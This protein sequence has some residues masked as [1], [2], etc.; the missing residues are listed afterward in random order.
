M[1]L[2]KWMHKNWDGWI[3]I[4]GL[5]ITVEMLVL[6]VM[7]YCGYNT[8]MF[9][10]G[11]MAQAIWSGTRGW[12]LE[13]TYNG[14]T[15]SRL[16]LHVELIYFLW[17]PLYA[18][19]P[20]PITL[21]TIQALLY[22]LGAFPLYHL[23]LRRIESVGAARIAVLIYLFYPVAQTAVLFDFHGD[24][25]AMPLLLFVL[26]ALD[27]R[28]WRTYA[29]WVGLALSCKFYVAWVVGTLGVMLWLRG[30]RRVG[31]YTALAA[32]LWGI[33]SFLVLRPLFTGASAAV[34]QVTPE[35]YWE[36]YFGQLVTGLSSTALARLLMAFIVFTPVFCLGSRALNWLILAVIVALPVLLSSGAGPS[37]YYGHHHYAM[38]VHF[39][40][41]SVVY[42]AANLK[43]AEAKKK[44]L[45]G[46]GYR[47][48]RWSFGMGITL[49]LTLA[50]N[51]Q[52][53]DTPLRPQFWRGVE[54]QGLSEWRYGRTARDEMKDLWLRQVVPSEASLSASPF[55]APHVVNRRFIYLTQSLDGSTDFPDYPWANAD[56]VVLDGLFDYVKPLA[57]GQF[58]GGSRFDL[59]PL[60]GVLADP[61]FALTASRDGLVL[62]QRKPLSGRALSQSIT[63]SATVS[64]PSLRASWGN[65]IGLSDVQIEVL[66]NRRF[67]FHYDWVGLPALESQPPLFAVS[68]LQ[69][70]ANARLLHLPGY[71]MLPTPS[72][73]LENVVHEEFEVEIAANLP[74]GRYP[75]SVGWYD[76]TNM[77]AYAT[78]ERSRI[79]TLYQVGVLE[80]R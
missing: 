24:T 51:A 56:Y 54:G 9:D 62:F 6:S 53:V 73:E 74:P 20:S 10:I 22:G 31:C 7:R 59:E 37:Y 76:S 28:A 35:G 46:V 26:E 69:G 38:V 72:W 75:V 2:L 15:L 34:A 13:F 65:A 29:V 58:S 68:Q 25:L 23:A 39:L 32:V 55:L 36:F 60:A 19:F 57:N 78:D 79:G 66:G 5:L 63:L 44:Q 14:V 48:Q 27:R 40:V 45:S 52:F 80:L 70:V 33:L 64:S 30:Q 4:A 18:I 41:I 3:L 1:D 17:V 61:E 47:F 77:F 11:N 8:N 12:P 21:L 71:A 49:V 16:A 67:R 50:F 43:N 42:G